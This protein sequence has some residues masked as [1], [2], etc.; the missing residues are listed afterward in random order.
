[1]SRENDKAS[2]SPLPRNL[3]D[4]EGKLERVIESPFS[5]LFRSPVQP[6]EIE[7]A[8]L[9]EIERSRKLGVNTI[10]VAN[11]YSVVIS[12]ADAEH[13]GDLASTLESDLATR[14]F[15]YTSNN[16]YQ[17]NT[18]PIVEF[19]VDADLKLGNLHVIGETLSVEAVEEKYGENYLF[20]A[21][22]NK[23]RVHSN[24]IVAN[25]FG[26]AGL[27][28]AGAGAGAA[29]A[30]E[31]LAEILSPLSGSS[32]P[33]DE[34][35]DEKRANP[36]AGIVEEPAMKSSAFAEYLREPQTV[37]SQKPEDDEASICASD[38]SDAGVVRH[39]LVVGKQ[40][41][42]VLG[43]LDRYVI[44][45]KGEVDIIL[46]DPQC[47]RYHAELTRTPTGWRITDLGSTN[48]TILN[49][50]EISTSS[51]KSHDQII[52]GTT[53]INFYEKRC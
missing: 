32:K 4:L 45:R 8:T 16:S 2:N 44:G 49:G 22:S 31:G 21:G 20:G 24:G 47:S 36:L 15:A 3:A 30:S 18:R 26:L 48:G 14:I 5:R 7:K 29:G 27:G 19:M 37:F 6:A 40:P 9:K 42:L 39:Y 17:L 46:E 11:H 52:I 33:V 1:M 38:G 51:L 53:A 13:L 35:A 25:D 43:N 41:P 34:K 12:P 23:A 28:A 10:Y 50:E